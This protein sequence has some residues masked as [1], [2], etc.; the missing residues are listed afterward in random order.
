MDRALL[1]I[2]AIAA[3]AAV[4]PAQG[5]TVAASSFT[6]SS[7]FGRGGFVNPPI[8]VGPGHYLPMQH[9]GHS[10]HIHVGDDG[11]DRSDRRDAFDN[12]SN[13]AYGYGA[14]GYY[15]YG[16]YDANRSFDPDKWND[17]WHNRPDRAFPRWVWHNQNCTEDR[18]WYSGAGWR[19][20]P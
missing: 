1:G 12:G 6:A 3:I 8:E 13:I 14:G 11:R 4:S 17:W 20:T 7:G 9:A 5:Q 15:D 16:D 2:V 19:C 18:M 10:R